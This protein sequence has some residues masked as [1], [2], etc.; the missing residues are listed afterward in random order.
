MIES[1]LYQY[2]EKLSCR[3]LIWLVFNKI[4]TIGEEEAVERAKDIAEQIG[5][6][7]D[8]LISAATG[9]NVQAHHCDIMDFISQPHACCGGRK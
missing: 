5:W 8:Y 9:Q 6:E 1:E 3:K 4:D 7:G 2:S